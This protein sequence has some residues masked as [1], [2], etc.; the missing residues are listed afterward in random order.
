MKR[1]IVLGGLGQFGR[2]AADELRLLGMPVQIVSRRPA[3]DLQVDAN[4]ANSI[5]SALRAGDVVID[6]AGPFHARS[7]ALLE[8]AIEIG[9][10]LIDI[11]DDLRYAEAIL[12][13][14][15]RIESAGI[16]VLSSASTVSAV[17][18]ATVHYSGVV[19]PRRVSAFLAPASRHTAN[20]GAALSLIRSVGRPVRVF[21][22]GHLEQRAG[23]SDPR[24][25]PMPAPIGAICGWLFESADAVYLPRIWPS[26]RDVAMY[27]DTNTAG[28]NILL[29]LAARWP[30]VRRSLERQ[31]RV[32]TW[33]ARWFGSSAGGIGYEI[34]DA[35]GRIARY[36]IVSDKNSFVAA[37]A[38]AVLAAQAIVEGRFPHRGLV[39]PDRHVEPTKLFAFLQSAGM[40]IREL[41]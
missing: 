25:F 4:D 15:P 14:Q 37:V 24:R 31:V 35:G 36:A 22:A 20:P 10:D 39:L 32:A 17:A 9:F 16:R 33:F 11:N 3:A 38:P 41:S 12:E 26:L 34:E 27:V 28:V 29:R 7:T 19:M 1:V 2:T 13:L 21:H 5:R 8:T 6:A 18:A 30:I 40:A 23:W